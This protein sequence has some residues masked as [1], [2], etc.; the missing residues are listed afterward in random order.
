MSAYAREVYLESTVLSADPI[1][2]VRLLY[3]AALEAV[4]NARR[5]LHQGDI[6]SRAGEIGKAHAILTELALSVD[7]E[8]GAF[9]SR[10]LV[11][12]YDYMQ[13]RL[14]QANLEQSDAPLAEVARL[15]ETLLEGWNHCRPAAA[16]WEEPPQPPRRELANQYEAQT[17]SL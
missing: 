10:N 13:R 16:P 9:L 12:L 2:L 5:F 17:W 3:Q 11:E 6:A 1:E 15:L 8:K 7:H 4:G 14:I